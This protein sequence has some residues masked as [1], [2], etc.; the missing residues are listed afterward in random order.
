[1]SLIIQSHCTLL[2]NEVLSEFLFQ[3]HFKVT[4]THVHHAMTVTRLAQPMPI[5]MLRSS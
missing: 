2:N 1:M 5:F 4:G 3:S